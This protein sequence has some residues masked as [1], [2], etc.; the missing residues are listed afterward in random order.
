MISL[1]KRAGEGPARSYRLASSDV[2]HRLRVIVIAQNAWGRTPATSRET[3]VIVKRPAGRTPSSPPSKKPGSGNPPGGNPVDYFATVPSSETGSPPA[4]IPRSDALCAAQVKPAA[5]VRPQN[6]TANN[7]IPSDP[8]AITWNP[9]LDGW[10]DFVGDRSSVTG[11]YKGTTG[12][13]LQW[14]SCKWGIDVNLVRADAWVES[15][16]IQST[17]GDDCG[18][19][20]EASYG[21]LQVKNENCSGQLIGGGWPYTEDDT[22]LDADYWGARLRACY[23]GA[24]YEDGSSWLYNGQTIAQVIAQNGSNG[25]AYALWGCIGSWYSGDWYDSGAQAYIS[26]VQS[27]YS[28]QPWLALES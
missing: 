15:S 14:V 25:Q 28:S 13:I 12:E 19:A 20:G 1:A 23:D 22:A 21:I 17:V 3:A 27:A 16:W 18:T 7:T 26:K 4:G 6:T 2:G 8:S 24:F 11:D 5:E 9:G 10:P